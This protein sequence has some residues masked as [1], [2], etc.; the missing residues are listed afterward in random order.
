[1]VELARIVG[2][3]RVRRVQGAER[4]R[5]RGAEK[6]RARGVERYDDLGSREAQRIRGAD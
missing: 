3:E 5:A 1:L 6:L 4:L 2:V